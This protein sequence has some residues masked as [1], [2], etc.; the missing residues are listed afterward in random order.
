LTEV[1]AVSIG[2][3]AIGV[4]DTYRQQLSINERT[5]LCA[6][7]PRGLPWFRRISKPLTQ[8]NVLA[9]PRC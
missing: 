1:H 5:G 8:K 4:Q 9:E 3:A 7:I 2:I 6:Y